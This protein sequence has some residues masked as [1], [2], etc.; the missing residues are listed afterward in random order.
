MD[1]WEWI[2]KVAAVLTIVSVVGGPIVNHPE[3]PPSPIVVITEGHNG[4]GN[5]LPAGTYQV[6]SITDQTQ[7]PVLTI[8]VP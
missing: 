1:N 3:E 2:Q 8:V 7:E 5:R 4:H 6:H